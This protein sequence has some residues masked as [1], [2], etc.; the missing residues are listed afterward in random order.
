MEEKKEVKEKT[1]KKKDQAKEE[2]KRLEESLREYEEKL[3]YSQAELINYRKRKDEE[4][5]NLLK[6]ANRDLILEILPVLDNFERAMKLDSS[7]Q[8][9]EIS[10]FLEGFKMIYTSLVEILKRYG[11]EEIKAEDQAFD[12]NFHE[13][14]MV[15]ADETKENGMVLEVLLKGYL[16]KGKVLRPATVKINQIEE[17]KG[18]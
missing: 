10:K 18:E 14:L 7:N 11:V 9:E 2:I 4:T 1:P 8:K 5:S 17:K 13:A 3:K 6:F 12:P 16:L 15:D